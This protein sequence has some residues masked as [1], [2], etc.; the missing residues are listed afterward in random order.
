MGGLCPDSGALVLLTTSA[1]PS[2]SP[3]NPGGS[4]RAGGWVGAG[5][6]QRGYWKGVGAELEHMQRG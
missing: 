2:L 6:G 5:V 4:L 1:F 3:G